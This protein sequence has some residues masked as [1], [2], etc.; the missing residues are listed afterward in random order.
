M[1]LEQ[2]PVR[3]WAGGSLLLALCM[4]QTTAWGTLYYALPVT[5]GAIAADTGWSILTQLPQH[6][7]LV[8]IVS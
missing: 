6:R 4:S 8:E 1:L 3:G 7:L 5:S 2:M